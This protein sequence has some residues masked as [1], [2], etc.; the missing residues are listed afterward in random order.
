LENVLECQLAMAEQIQALTTHLTTPMEVQK[1]ANQ[2]PINLRSSGFNRLIKSESEQAL[3][4]TQ[5]IPRDDSSPHTRNRRNNSRKSV[6]NYDS[7]VSDSEADHDWDVVDSRT[8]CQT[9][10][11]EKPSQP[12]NRKL[13]HGLPRFK[14]ANG[15]E[16]PGEFLNVFR[17]MCLAEGYPE[18]LMAI[19]LSTRLDDSDAIWLES[20]IAERP[21]I[22]SKWS[23]LE[24]TF[25]EHFE[26]PNANATHLSQIRALKMDAN[27]GVQRYSDQFIN[28]AHKLK[29]QLNDEAVIYQFKLG[30]T[31]SLIQ[32]LSTVEANH[33]LNQELSG[34]DAST[35]PVNI[36]IKM[37][38]RIEAND[39]I[40]KRD[41][42]PNAR[43]D[44]K[45]DPKHGFQ[46][47]PP[48]VDTPQVSSYGQ[49]THV[50]QHRKRCTKCSRYGHL[51]EECH[52]K[53]SYQSSYYTCRCDN[54]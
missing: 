49:S 26:N 41:N 28:L 10:T 29:W 4:I 48:H 6:D 46:Q 22:M 7:L 12:H 25:M 44:V 1:S 45:P 34:I 35:V 3:D 17:R 39:R 38:I 47:K 32:Q 51:A 54:S 21:E 2:S 40:V 50:R 16:D 23:G 31:R 11:P 13:P 42:Q 19:A 30:L 15:T 43:I 33:I 18:A 5:P 53:T 37:A 8:A 14:G 24:R 27:I 36:L 9:I 20:C 52:R